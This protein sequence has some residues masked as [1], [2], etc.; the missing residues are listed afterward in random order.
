MARNAPRR[1]FSLL[2][3]ILALSLAAVLVGLLVLA[4]RT[5]LRVGSDMKQEV[6]RAAL[7]RNVLQHIARD[8]QNIVV[9]AAQDV[10]GLSTAPLPSA[11]DLSSA[12]GANAGGS[13]SGGSSGNSP[14][15]VPSGNS[16]SG[17]GGSS[18]GGGPGSG[19]SGSGGS[20]VGRSGGGSRGAGGGSSGDS[21]SGG[22]GS[23]GGS[24]GAG[25]SNN[26][27]LNAASQNSSNATLSA[28]VVSSNTVDIPGVYGTRYELAFDILR[29][30]EFNPYHS[31]TSGSAAAPQRV[32]WSV[33]ATPGVSVDPATTSNGG[34]TRHSQARAAA[35][36]ASENGQLAGSEIMPLS[37]RVAAMEFR[38]F[39]GAQW[40]DTWDSGAQ[41]ALPV[42]I[43]I[44]VLVLSSAEAGSPQ[45]ASA[46]SG[47][48]GNSALLAGGVD[49]SD[50]SAIDGGLAG[51][52]A[53]G[54]VGKIFRRV[55]YLPLSGL[56]PTAGAEMAAANA[57]TSDD[58]ASS[59]TG[60]SGRGVSP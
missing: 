42:A 56:S 35:S 43:E 46:L 1:A 52:G 18:G 17:S 44:A 20:G 45:V 34:L 53:G 60:G 47:G 19:G 22:A 12:G 57:G 2:E 32:S 58:A 15:G 24:S 9:P 41:A 38:Y 28:E 48:A 54:S 7:A 27:N 25:A 5:F 11:D 39:D 4:T 40:I 3:V 16:G 49:V 37:A 31:Q 30:P 6:E 36:W 33:A 55:V 21:N 50:A 10:S 59:G 14:G 8:L 23:P 13:P 29:L 51:D 26:A